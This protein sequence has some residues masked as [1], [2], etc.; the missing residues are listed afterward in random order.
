SF[1]TR[2]SSDL[3]IILM[4]FLIVSSIL[5][6]VVKRNKETFYIF[7]WSISLTILIIGI[8]L[9]IA[10][11]GGIS[12]DLQDFYFFNSVIKKYAQYFYLTTSTLWFIVAIGMYSFPVFLVLLAIHYSGFEWLK[13]NKLINYF[14]FFPP[15]IVL[16]LNFPSVFY[17]LTD[18]YKYF[19]SVLSNFSLVWILLYVLVSR[20]EE[21]TSEL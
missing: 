15:M 10:N 9:Y 8:M 12:K 21:H 3:F 17:A 19:E 18:S 7:G 1:P 4:I 6:L 16:I 20:S 14:I 13:K 2:R 11:K 5:M